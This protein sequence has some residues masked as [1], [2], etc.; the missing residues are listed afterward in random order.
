[1]LSAYFVVIT[2]RCWLLSPVALSHNCTKQSC[3]SGDSL[4]LYIFFFYFLFFAF[5]IFRKMVWA[6]PCCLYIELTYYCYQIVYQC[7]DWLINMAANQLSMTAT[8]LYIN[9]SKYF[10]GIFFNLFLSFFCQ[11]IILINFYFTSIFFDNLTLKY[12]NIQHF[13]YCKFIHVHNILK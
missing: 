7:V 9:I 4:S 13:L 2:S 1:M 3:Y 8:Q 6:Y 5:S 12:F 11:I 10:L